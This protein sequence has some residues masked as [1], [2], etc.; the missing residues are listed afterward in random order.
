MAFIDVQPDSTEQEFFFI[1]CCLL[2]SFSPWFAIWLLCVCVCTEWDGRRRQRPLAWGHTIHSRQFLNILCTK[3][4]RGHTRHIRKTDSLAGEHICRATITSKTVEM[5][6]VYCFLHTSCLCCLTTTTTITTH[7]HALL[8]TR[9]LMF[10]SYRIEFQSAWYAPSNADVCT[11]K[12]ETLGVDS[13]NARAQT[14]QFI[15]WM[16]QVKCNNIF[17]F[18]RELINTHMPTTKTNQAT[19]TL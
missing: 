6:R 19:K 1:F 17:Y 16:G 15:R 10:D 8:C 9:V 2:I 12:I 7:T 3:S 4:K 5:L 13:Q 14:Q 18:W 11:G